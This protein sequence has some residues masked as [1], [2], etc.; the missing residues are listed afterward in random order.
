[1]TFNRWIAV[2]ML[3]AL[4]AAPPAFAKEKSSGSFSSG[5]LT[6]DSAL[7]SSEGL[8]P[9]E[10]AANVTISPANL[11]PP[12][13]KLRDE[14]ITL[15]LAADSSSAVDVSLTVNNITHDQVADDD[16][17]GNGCGAPTAKQGAD[18][19][20]TDF[21]SLTASGALLNAT[22]SLSIPVI[23][24]RRER[25]RKDGTRTYEVSVTC[26]D[27]TNAVCDSA[28]VLLNVTVPKSRG[29]RRGCR[30]GNL[31]YC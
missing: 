31:P 2:L 18:W 16:A 6:E 17:G 3:F 12:N 15:S 23:Q 13:H 9:G 11:W 26:C 27:T 29:K 10:A 4:V 24:L 14:A 19:A 22:D 21:S 7:Q 20:P 25:C 30:H 8:D 28:P 1:M 5:F